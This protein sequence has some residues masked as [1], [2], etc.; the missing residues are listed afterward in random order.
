MKNNLT[1]IFGWYGTVAIL[2]AYALV[3]F[4]VISS[5]GFLF[6]FLNASGA[7]GIILVSMSKKAYQP[8]VLNTIWAVIAVIAII[9]ILL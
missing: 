5:Q 6:Q 7:V 4:S 8:A 3:S 2:S 1:E 9:K